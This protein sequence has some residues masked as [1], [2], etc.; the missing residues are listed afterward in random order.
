MREDSS[1]AGLSPRDVDAD[2]VIAEEK[3]RHLAPSEAQ[4]ACRSRFGWQAVTN[5]VRGFP[6][7]VRKTSV[8]SIGVHLSEDRRGEDAIQSSKYPSELAETRGKTTEHHEVRPAGS[9]DQ[10]G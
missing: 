10:D 4:R 6:V 3:F 2:V 5:M 1:T 7:T 8:E 9:P